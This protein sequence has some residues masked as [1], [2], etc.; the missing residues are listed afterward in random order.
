MRAVF[1]VSDDGSDT[2][3][4]IPGH[5]DCGCVI[6]RE[7]EEEEEEGSGFSLAY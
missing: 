5:G 6:G 2:V 3:L 7:E 4:F 1:F